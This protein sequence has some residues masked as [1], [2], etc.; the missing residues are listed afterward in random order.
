MKDFSGLKGINVRYTVLIS[1]WNF[2]SQDLSLY[3][4]SITKGQ[5]FTCI[6]NLFHPAECQFSGSPVLMS[7]NFNVKFAIVSVDQ[8]KQKMLI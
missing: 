2:N 8:F 5:E 4:N 6:S 3:L 1:Q 7:A